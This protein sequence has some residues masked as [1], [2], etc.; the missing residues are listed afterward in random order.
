MLRWSSTLQLLAALLFLMQ[1]PLHQKHELLMAVSPDHHM[2]CNPLEVQSEPAVHQHGSHDHQGGASNHNGHQTAESATESNAG[3][4]S[5]PAGKHQNHDCS[6]CMP[7]VSEVPGGF[8][9]PVPIRGGFQM[10]RLVPDQYLADLLR[11]TARGPP[12]HL[13]S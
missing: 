6:C 7:M 12:V 2:A 8:V 3:S 1:V 5:I 9:L 10:S 4:T 11:A 13:S